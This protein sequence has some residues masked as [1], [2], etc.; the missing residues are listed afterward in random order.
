MSAPSALRSAMCCQPRSICRPVMAAAFISFAVNRAT[1]A[2]SP[3]G[4]HEMG[5]SPSCLALN[6]AGTRLYSGN[7]TDRVGRRQ[8]RHCQRLRHQ[9][10]GREAQAAEHRSFRWRRSDVCEHPSVGTVRAG[11]Q[12]FRRLRRGVADSRPMVGWAPPPISR[13]MPARSAPPRRPT[14]H[15]AALRSAD[16][17]GLMRT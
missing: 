7:E 10:S 14:R 6:A 4:I 15:R 11:G 17:I 5:T 16:T 2:M 13:S 9:S 12:L 1:G 8:G 3:A